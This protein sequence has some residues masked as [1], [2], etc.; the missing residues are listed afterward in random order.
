[1]TSPA[2]SREY[3]VG[4]VLTLRSGANWK[5]DRHTDHAGRPG[6]ALVNPCNPNHGTAFY[7]DVLDTLVAG[8]PTPPPLCTTLPPCSLCGVEVET[9]AD[10]LL[11]QS[12]GCWWPFDGLDDKPGEWLDDDGDTEQCPSVIQPFAD[13]ASARA[14]VR[15]NTYRCFLDAEHA[16]DHRNPDYCG[17]WRDGD[18]RASFARASA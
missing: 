11:C 7:A 9:D 12:C 14:D 15:W 2:T 18:P 16:G 8:R 1:V 3:R 5:V 10:G 4:Q 17:T 13:L 6:V